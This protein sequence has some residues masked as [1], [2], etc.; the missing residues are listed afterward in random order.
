MKTENSLSLPVMGTAAATQ[1]IPSQWMTVWFMPT[2]QASLAV[3]METD[4][5][6]PALA[7]MRVCL[8]LLPSQ[9]SANPLLVLLQF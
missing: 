6:V 5:S 1:E 9:K 8:H 3:T 4:V 2:A 7:G